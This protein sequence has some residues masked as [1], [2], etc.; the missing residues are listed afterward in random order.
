MHHLWV[1]CR[2]RGHSTELSVRGKIEMRRLRYVDKS[3]YLSL[4]VMTKKARG[5][6]SHCGGTLRVLVRIWCRRG[7]SEFG[8][9]LIPRNLLIL[10][11]GRNYKNIEFTQVRYTAGT[12]TSKAVGKE[13]MFVK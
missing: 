13:R 4:A 8:P 6:E 10:Q 1:T 11:D 2:I 3:I 7:E 9:P 5:L 12:R